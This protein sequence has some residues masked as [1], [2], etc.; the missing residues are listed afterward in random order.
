MILLE[1]SQDVLYLMVSL[2]GTP[3]T[4]IWNVVIRLN[5]CLGNRNLLGGHW[6][7]FSSQRWWRGYV[8]T[9]GGKKSEVWSLSGR[10]IWFFSMLDVRTWPIVEWMTSQRTNHSKQK[11][12]SWK[13]LKKHNV[14]KT[15]FV[16]H[17]SALSIISGI[18]RST[19]QPVFA[20]MGMHTK[21]SIS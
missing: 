5:A 10:R 7:K 3:K 8:Q 13:Q 4:C 15:H 17:L 12:W 16:L 2:N 9:L 6:G 1:S 20:E 21:L 19:P 14:M 18:R 11:S